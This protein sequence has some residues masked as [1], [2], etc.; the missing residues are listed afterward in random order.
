[1]TSRT[2]YHRLFVSIMF[3]AGVF[4]ILTH[5]VARPL[6]KS[7]KIE[8]SETWSGLVEITGD[9]TIP[10]GITVTIMPGTTVAIRANSDDQQRGGD[11]IIDEITNQDPSARA[12]YT[13]THISI[14]ISGSLVAAGKHDQPIRF[15]S[16]HPF[17]RHTDWD[18]IKFLKGS[19][20]ILKHCVVEW[21]HTGPA[22]HDTDDVVV[23]HSIIRHI[24]WGGLHAFRNQP[25][26]EFNYLD[27]IGHEA[28]DTHRAS[29]VIRHNVILRAR[30]AFV[31]NHYHVQSGKPVV[32][33]DNIVRDCSNM[34]QLQENN[35]S[36][37]RRN[38]FV[39]SDRKIGPWVYQGFVLDAEPH[40]VGMGLADNVRVT[41][42]DN[43]FAGISGF[44]IY[45]ERI[46]PNG[47]IGHTTKTPEPFE[48]IG[49]QSV[50][51]ARNVFWGEG[52]EPSL[53]MLREQ[54]PDIEITRN[55][56]QPPGH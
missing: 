48:I 29:P 28:F 43:R 51:I 23:S 34:G 53:K 3:L 37:I 47:G 14:D 5:G 33:E 52:A 20:G 41:I 40:S 35:Y 42:E 2:F 1:M 26:F 16:S 19:S 27:D 46:G 4:G 39:G 25:L 32:F 30:N 18:G 7:G 55:T 24:F 22:L 50:R 9:I 56:I 13:R 31:F 12:E 49:A 54:I 44:P 11:H 21:A 10:A 38:I 17:P 45:Y 36:M 15:T 6:L 8:E